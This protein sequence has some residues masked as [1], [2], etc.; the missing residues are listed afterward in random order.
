MGAH[1]PI[2]VPISKGFKVPL[3]EYLYMVV[4]VIYMAQINESTARMVAGLSGNPIPLLLPILLTAILL[5]RN[6]ITFRCR[7]LFIV[8]GLFLIWAALILFKYNAFTAT[9]DFSYMFFF[10]Y[11]IIIAYIHIRVYKRNLFYI[12]EQIMVLAAIISIPFWLLNTLL[13]G[14]VEPAFLPETAIGYNVFYLY[15]WASASFENVEE[16]FLITMRNSGF[17]WEPGRFAIMLDLALYVNLSRK[18]VKLSSNLNLIFILLALATTQSTTG[19]IIAIILFILFSFKKNGKGVLVLIGTLIFSFFILTR[20]DFMMEK[21]VNQMNVGDSLLRMAGEMQY[22]NDTREEGEFISA[23]SRFESLFFDTLNITNDPWLGYSRNVQHSFFYEN[24]SSHYSL[25]SGFLKVFAQF[26]IPYGLFIYFLLFLS[27]VRISKY[28][29][30]KKPMALA[31]LFIASLI[32]YELWCVPI[33]TSFW[34]FGIF[35][36]Q[37]IKLTD[38]RR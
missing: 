8:L 6:P 35:Y 34:L 26:G 14:I 11:A 25:P 7:N 2:E 1:K 23:L 16:L 21:V 28:F 22:E 36:K 30:N 5:W 33:F 4:M 19:Y 20:L 10:F 38:T 15:N 12:Y 9:A 13:F 18:G 27:S 31:V 37:E 3:F 29:P 32:S 24:I 17:S